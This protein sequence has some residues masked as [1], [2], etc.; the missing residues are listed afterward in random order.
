M[1]NQSYDN[2]FGNFSNKSKLAIVMVLMSGPKNVTEI[3]KKVNGEQSA[4]SHN[5]KKLTECHIL[6]VRQNG[7]KRIYSLN[8]ETVV[9]M[10]KIVA[11]H[12][13]HNCDCSECNDK[14]VV[15]VRNAV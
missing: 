14:C 11:K 7:K 2:F 9:P 6:E 4:V 8:K 15:R 3:A 5:L 10:L 1:N 13:S 12:V